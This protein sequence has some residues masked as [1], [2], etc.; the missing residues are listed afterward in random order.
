MLPIIWTCCTAASG[1]NMADGSSVAEG[2]HMAGTSIGILRAEEEAVKESK[3]YT[4]KREKSL[5]V[6]RQ[7][8]GFCMYESHTSAK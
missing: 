3:Q 2:S 6:R 5:T 8:K 1:G 7:Q 4:T